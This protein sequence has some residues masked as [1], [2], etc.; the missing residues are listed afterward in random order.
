MSEGLF[1]QLVTDLEGAFKIDIKTVHKKYDE[2]DHFAGEVKF[3]MRSQ[4]SSGTNKLF[5]ISGPLFD[6]L[7]DGGILVVDELD[8]S[9]HPLLTLA[10]TEL[11]H[12]T[13]FNPN[14]AQLIFATHDTNLLYYGRYRRDQIYF[15]E[16]NKSGASEVYSLVE[17][18]EEGK[19]IR[20]D[21]SF[22]KDYI[23]GRYGAI[24]FIGNLSNI[25]AEWQER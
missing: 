7:Q 9:L 1:K 22:E 12:S 4:E 2:D 17:Y 8:A 10:F 15:A 3:D 25:M 16:K 14:N 18:K 19:T 24:P 23:E 11:F 20:K 21:R 13:E 5:N 6:V